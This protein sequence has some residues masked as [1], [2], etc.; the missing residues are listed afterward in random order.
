MRSP[1]IKSQ[2]PHTRPSSPSRV[3]NSTQLGSCLQAL[4]ALVSLLPDISSAQKS[5]QLFAV[6]PI[7]HLEFVAHIIEFQVPEALPHWV[8]QPQQIGSPGLL[9][10]QSCRKGPCGC[11]VLHSEPAQRGS[12]Q[13]SFLWCHYLMSE[14]T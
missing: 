12:L 2:K 1:E 14:L 6:F 9:G 3:N 4:T 10:P 13:L 7:S 8:L 11:W 5:C